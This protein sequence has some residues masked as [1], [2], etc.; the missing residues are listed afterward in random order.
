MTETAARMSTTSLQQPPQAVPADEV[1]PVAMPARRAV[2][3]RSVGLGTLLVAVVCAITPYNDYVINNSFL[4]GNFF[5]PALVLSLLTMVGINGLVNKHKPR[6][7]LSGGEMG[8][9]TAMLMVACA[10]PGQGLMRNLI[11]LPVS[12]FYLGR[13]DDALWRVFSNLGLP[14]WLWPVDMADGKTSD[15]VN[16]FY[17]RTPDGQSIPWRP[18]IV[19]LIGWLSF[20]ACFY[21]A[22]LALASLLRQHWAVNERVPFPLAQLGTMLIEPPERGRAAN[23]LLSSRSFW[24]FAGAVFVLQSLAA[25]HV[26]H[27]QY[28]PDLSF[29]FDLN[30]TLTE[31]PWRYLIGEVK[32]STLFFTF[33]GITYFIQLRVGFSLW[34]IF[35]AEAFITMW[36]RN[37][38]SDVTQEMWDDQH[39]GACATFLVGTLWVGRKHWGLV[40]RQAVGLDRSSAQGDYAWRARAL[41]VAVVGMYLWLL[42]VGVSVAFGL[43]IVA[44]MLACH[45]VI[46]RIVA[47]TGLPFMRVHPTM[48]QMTSM[49]SPTLLTG[50]DMFFTGFSSYVGPVACRESLLTHALHGT[51]VGAGGAEDESHARSD[52]RARAYRSAARRLMAAMAWA[53]VVAVAVSI[54]S[55]L[56]CYYNYT[57]PL[58]KG[59]QNVVNF[60]GSIEMPRTYIG[61]QIV[62][63]SQGRYP[64][65][66]HDAMTQ[67]GIGVGMTA[68]LMFGALRYA[69]WPLMPV[70]YVVSTTWY[71][72]VAWWS[73]LVGWAAK[74]LILRFGGASLYQKLK[75]AFVGMII[76]EAVATGFWLIVA[77][78]LVWTGHE[79][80]VIRFLPR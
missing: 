39:V 75:P 20:V 16:E 78:V 30:K 54:V 34:A 77:I 42:V 3:W 4:T 32:Q 61:K 49:S 53:L 27:Q 74:V 33:V 12:F 56:W 43:A 65:R 79:Y 18:W 48:Y 10:V 23:G 76:G 62:D 21:S 52:E 50:R 55:S 64:P 47:E 66:A 59:E 67:V 28:F 14:A 38:G 63:H 60:W 29:T 1:L 15:V 72:K 57:I 71:V 6:V 35:I 46:A 45:V 17:G 5:P 44:F 26:Y 37:A 51:L 22:L 2:S 69:S 24:I 13:G 68:V 9:V 7:A 36:F 19:P 70:A 31:E 41:I 11:P 8:V 80:Q 25:L 58:N 40:A 73:I